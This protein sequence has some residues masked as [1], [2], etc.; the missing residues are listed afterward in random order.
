MSL[1]IH[2]VEPCEIDF[3]FDF[4]FAP[5]EGVPS[6]EEPL[7]EAQG[8]EI[9][10]FGLNRPSEQTSEAKKQPAQ[11]RPQ[12]FWYYDYDCGG[13]VPAPSHLIYRPCSPPGPG[14][15]AE[16]STKPVAETASAPV[17]GPTEAGTSKKR[18]IESDDGAGSAEKK[19]RTSGTQSTAKIEAPQI[20]PAQARREKRKRD[21]TRNFFKKR[22]EMA[23]RAAEEFRE[24]YKDAMERANAFRERR[25]EDDEIQ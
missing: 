25:F 16:Q 7:P 9:D 24:K 17:T 5:F 19:Q 11:Q 20:T 4:E 1:D 22:E 8:E 2:T 10:F 3:D 21:A 6:F 13:M 23:L 12:R 14:N 18:K 15:M